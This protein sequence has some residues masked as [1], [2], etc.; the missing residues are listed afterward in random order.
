VSRRFEWRD[1][2][3][4]AE[5]SPTA[6]RVAPS[7]QKAVG[8]RLSRYMNDDGE[9]WPSVRRL[10]EETSFSERTVQNALRALVENGLLEIVA[11]G[12]AGP[13]S[14]TRYR[15]VLRAARANLLRPSRVKLA[16]KRA[17]LATGKGEAGSPEDVREDEEQVVA[18]DDESLD[19]R[20]LVRRLGPAAPSQRQEW[21]TA[22]HE[23]PDGFRR[24]VES[25]RGDAP[26]GVVTVQVRAGTHMHI[27]RGAVDSARR[28]VENVGGLL[29]EN[30][31]RAELRE[32]GVQGE[33]LDALLERGRELRRVGA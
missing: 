7:T 29:E 33:Q 1:W 31:L 24:V 2:L 22:Y 6:A 25:A 30:D 16:T 5:L 8:Q 4:T 21:L 32:R 15:A 14:T 9:A 28:Y 13:G 3:A 10:A 18:D 20:T 19:F 12:G 11:E 17:N 23:S 27:R 26:A